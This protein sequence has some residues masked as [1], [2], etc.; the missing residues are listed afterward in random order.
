MSWAK[1]DCERDQLVLFPTRLDDAVDPDHIVRSLDSIL[2]RIDWEPL[3]K[4]YDQ[5]RGQPPIHPRIICSVILYGLMCRIRA[6]RRL[7]DALKNRL[8][9]RWLAHGMSIDHTT[10]CEFRRKHSGQLRDLF[11]QTVL[12]GQESKL[13]EFQRIAFDGTR[14]RANNRRTGTRSPEEIRELR[15]ELQEEF[16][17][18]NQKAESEDLEDEELF[19]KSDDDDDYE[20]KQRKL[21]NACNAVQAALAELQKIENSTETTPNRLPITDPESRFGRNKDGG[22]APNYTPT[23]TV[24]V[25]S[26]MIVDQTVIPQ[27]NESAHL[28]ATISQIQEDYG[29]EHP[30]PI[31][32]ADSLMATGENLTACEQNSIN[33]YSPVPNAHVGE[34][35]AIRRDLNEPVP[36]GQIDSL[37]VKNVTVDG[38]RTQRFDKQAFVYDDTQDKYFCP[39]G[40]PL[41]YSSTYKTTYYGRSVTRKRY[42]AEQTDC[43]GCVLASRCLSGR[44]KFRQIDQGE[45]QPALDRQ[46]AKMQQ[47]ESQAIYAQRRHAG[48]YPFAV[49]K[50]FYGLR[51]FLTRSLARVKQ[52]WAWA[53]TAFNL[54]KLMIH[55][56]PGPS[57]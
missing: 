8:D 41:N 43:T 15:A 29:L 45:Y 52:E 47:Q 31:V 54:Q 27:S 40:K 1:R 46:K 56:A 51:Q 55:L 33:L 49:I 42:R 10:I 48:E 50:Q 12:I 18:Q 32:L 4:T 9:F 5:R 7:E 34:N 53:T 38:E 16:E 22:F 2:D 14:V 37:P 36:S 28:M 35:P 44:S 30:V 23:V 26:G 19:D 39:A 6:S 11:V 57:G 17:R 3:E 21:E 25:S 13:V 20:Q 24:D